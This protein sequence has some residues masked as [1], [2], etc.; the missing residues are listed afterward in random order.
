MS[1]QVPGSR[2]WLAY[3]G[4]LSKVLSPGLRLGWMTASQ[5]VLEKTALCKQFSDSN[6]STFT[7]AV[8]AEY[9]K[10]GRLPAAIRRA[11]VAYL[12]RSDAMLQA[13]RSQLGSAVAFEEPRGGF[14]LWASLKLDSAASADSAA[15]HRRAI[16]QGV[17]FVTGAAF[18]PEAPDASTLRLSFATEGVE[19]IR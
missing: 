18:Y 4:S 1:A 16:E 2:E 13:L 12:Q 17:A 6:T 3:C 7:Q 19:A 15:I 14:F 5:A 9:L 10:A 8:A 11:R